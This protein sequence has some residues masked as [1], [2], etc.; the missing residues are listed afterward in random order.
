MRKEKE[1]EEMA[2]K[3][4]AEYDRLISHIPLTR[5]EWESAQKVLSALSA[6]KWVLG[7]DKDLLPLSFHSSKEKEGKDG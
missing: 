2:R 6:L 1:I 4:G 3:L 5:E 7:G